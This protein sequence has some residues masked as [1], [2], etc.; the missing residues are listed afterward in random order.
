MMTRF[1]RIIGSSECKDKFA[2]KSISIYSDSSSP[3]TC[4]YIRIVCFFMKM[5][6]IVYIWIRLFLI[7][8]DSLYEVIK[9]KF[10]V[11]AHAGHNNTTGFHE[12]IVYADDAHFDAYAK[13]S[14]AGH[15]Q[16]RTPRL[17]TWSSRCMRN[18]HVKLLA[19]KNEAPAAT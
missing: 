11:A 16:I 4:A 19:I 7:W 9:H 1:A 14:P 17:S 13:P 2:K 6:Y 5:I 18:R 15:I 10:S 8:I 3:Q 12:Y